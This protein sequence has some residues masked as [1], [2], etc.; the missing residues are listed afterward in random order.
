MIGHAERRRVVD[1]RDG[2]VVGAAVARVVDE[3]ERHDPDPRGDADDARAVERRRDGPRDM[4]P[5]EVLA[6][7][8]D[9]VVVV[10][11][12]PAVDVVDVAVAVVV[13]AI[14]GIRA[15]FAGV[16][17]RPIREVGMAEVDAVV[18]D[19]H[20]HVGVASFEPQGFEPIDVDV[21]G[22]GLDAF[23]LDP[24]PAVVEAPELTE[25]GLVGDVV[26]QLALVVVG[27][28][29]DPR[30]VVQLAPS[31]RGRAALGDDDLGPAV[32]ARADR[33]QPVF[34]GDAGALRRRRVGPVADEDLVSRSRACGGGA[35]GPRRRRRPCRR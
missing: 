31:R 1:G 35:V 22:A 33:G 28:G 21:D 6:G 11:E 14:V 23:A 30:V 29:E 19:R 26:E 27:D 13:L 20:D 18:D 10:A 15:G 32:G 8:G 2:H 5:V 16:G 12:V 17:P 3:L 4:G 9:G 7:I 24:L 34:A 25:S